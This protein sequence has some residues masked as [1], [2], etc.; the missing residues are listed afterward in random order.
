MKVQKVNFQCKVSQDDII[1]AMCS[2]MLSFLDSDIAILLINIEDIGYS[3]IV[4]DGD[5]MMFEY[6]FS[7]LIEIDEGNAIV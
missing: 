5:S 6:F 3:C 4:G 7:D 2:I 1:D